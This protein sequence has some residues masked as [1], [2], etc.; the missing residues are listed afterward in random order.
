MGEAIPTP[1]HPHPVVEKLMLL[2][3][4]LI[5]G[6]GLASLNEV[7]VILLFARMVDDLG[8]IYESSLP[9]FSDM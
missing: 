5:L 9:G 4:L 2:V 8:I 1:I 3:N 7:G 6:Y